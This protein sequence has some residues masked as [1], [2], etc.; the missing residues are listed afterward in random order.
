MADIFLSYAREDADRASALA[1]VLETRG[2]SVFWDRNI[3]AG[4]TFASII[5]RAIAEARCIV[6]LWSVSS[7][8]SSWV[9]EEAG[10]ARARSILLPVLLEDVP[11]PL[12]FR[13][14]QSADLIG[15]NGEQDHP[16]LVD[17]FAAIESLSPPAE[18]KP[19]PKLEFG[20]VFV[21]YARED[22]QYVEKLI[23]YL[24]DCHLSVW[25]DNR[26]D[27]G[28]QWWRTI[29]ANLRSCLAMVV[30]MTPEAEES[31]W[32]D[33]EILLADELNKPIYP[34]L[35]RGQR[36]PIFVGTQFHDVTDDA[37][38]P[39]D[40]IVALERATAK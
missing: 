24:K 34:L 17:L 31:K 38:P 23:S 28:E 35:L 40:F 33:R 29:V 27:Y 4:K 1:S 18:K 22:G 15:W 30:V 26:I 36:F 6:V 9:Q 5:G 39:P 11:P 25:A 32:V 19:S 13:S 37:M 10:E 12:G 14:I 21:S 20:D 16:G 2:W 3:R 8:A 7:V